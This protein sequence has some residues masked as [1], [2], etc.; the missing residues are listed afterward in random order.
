M[1]G[2]KQ[3]SEDVPGKITINSCIC[4]AS[5]LYPTATGCCGLHNSSQNAALV[6]N[7]FLSYRL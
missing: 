4:A 6:N 5:T 1:K 7:K 2:I 3:V